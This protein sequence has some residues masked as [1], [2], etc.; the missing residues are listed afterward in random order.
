LRLLVVSIA[1]RCSIAKLRVPALPVVVPHPDI[2]DA[3]QVGQH[4][5]IEEQR[6][7]LRLESAKEGFRIGVVL[8]PRTV[9]ET[10]T[11]S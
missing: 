1:H 4:L 11:P 9:H 6:A 8:W 5:G 2:Y 7:V 3:H 10:R